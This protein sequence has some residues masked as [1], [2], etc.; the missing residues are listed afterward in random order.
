MSDMPLRDARALVRD[1]RYRV[2]P[3]AVRSASPRPPIRQTGAFPQSLSEKKPACDPTW[4]QLDHCALNHCHRMFRKNLE[5]ASQ[6]AVAHPPSEG[7]FNNP[8]FR[9]NLETV[10]KI[11]AFY[12]FEFHLAATRNRLAI[13]SI[14]YPMY[15]P[16][17]Q[18]RFNN[19][20]P[21]IRTRPSRSRAPSRCW[22]DASVTE[23]PNRN[24][25]V[26]AS[27]CRFLPSAF[28]PAS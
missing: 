9:Q 14:N 21:P 22:T 28:L 4:H 10:H 18:M 26:S 15:P 5:I 17:P 24:P 19:P 11:T 8:A 23:I 2:T 13:S 25:L 12:D 6:S 16:S 3:P 20:K 7:S 27:T 1:V